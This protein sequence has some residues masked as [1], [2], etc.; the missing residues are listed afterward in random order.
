MRFLGKNIAPATVQQLQQDMDKKSVQ[1]EGIKQIRAI[2]GVEV[3][4]DLLRLVERGEDSGLIGRYFSNAIKA[5]LLRQRESEKEATLTIRLP[6]RLLDSIEAYV[7]DGNAE[8][9]SVFVR[10]LL[11]FYF[12]L[13]QSNKDLESLQS[14]A[15]CT[16]MS[17]AYNPAEFV[18]FVLFK[19]FLSAIS[20]K[21]SVELLTN[22]REPLAKVLSEFSNQPIETVKEFIDFATQVAPQMDQI[23]A[24]ATEGVN[25]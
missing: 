6:Q 16:M 18:L 11:E 24:G 17:I 19:G 8:N 7:R 2:L 13:M 10:L 12:V 23:K 22:L 3:C 14:V 1:E 15:V 25:R 20:G 9:K 21:K 5:T 4:T